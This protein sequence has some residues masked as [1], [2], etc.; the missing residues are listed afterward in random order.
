MGVELW[1]GNDD[2]GRRLD[3]ILRKALPELPLSGI[4]RLLRRKQVLVDGV[5]GLAAAR[6]RSGQSIRVEGLEM[7]KSGGLPPE[8]ALSP[9]KPFRVIWEGAGLLALNKDAG[10]QVHGPN[11][12]DE[13]VRTFLQ[14][15]LPVSLSFRPGPLHRLDKPTSGI[16]V[17][18]A[19]LEGARIFSAL[20]RA[21][22]LRKR[23][24]ALVDGKFMAPALWEEVL[25]RD[26]RRKKTEA[27][28]LLRQADGEEV[29]PESVYGPAK[30]AKTRVFPLAA[31]GGYSLVLLEIETGR[32]HQIRSQAAFHGHPLAGDRKYGGSFLP[33]GLLLHALSLEF[34]PKPGETRENGA[35]NAAGWDGLWGKR[36]WAELP[37]AFLTQIRRI[38]GEKILKFMVQLKQDDFSGYFLGPETG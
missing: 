30:T 16:L 3:R 14:G 24:L 12:L 33:G 9:G 34:P 1:A 25:V 31:G 22:L 26:T 20:L 35:W 13:Q 8:G 11:G 7:P 2:D 5:P 17:F 18:S 28:V 27:S 19:S 36:L 15:K 29:G 10:V 4:H 6:I 38:F 23:Y 21:R 32:T 37:G